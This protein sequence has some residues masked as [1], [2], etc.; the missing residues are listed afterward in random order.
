MYE[1]IIGNQ[2]WADSNLNVVEFSNGDIIFQAT[3]AEEWT[4]ALKN[5]QPAW[6]Y[7][8]YDENQGIKYG[9]LYNWYAVNDSRCIAPKGW[10]IP[11]SED[12]VS[13]VNLVKI[14]KLYT[15]KSKDLW[16]Y[17]C[18]FEEREIDRI[19]LDVHQNGGKGSDILGF[20]GIPSGRCND[21]G[22]FT[23]LNHFTFY[24]LTT[25][26]FLA[27]CQAKACGTP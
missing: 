11:S 1:I 19:D 12:F 27:S 6:C 25:M 7:Y 10:R 22:I 9:K 18:L 16:N 15:L 4:L 5:K 2:I 24:R 17:E 8:N 13:L 21:K 20:N 26:D 3:S 23:D 14:E